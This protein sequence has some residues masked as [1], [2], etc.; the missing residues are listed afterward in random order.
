MSPRTFRIALLQQL[1]ELTSEG[2]CVSVGLLAGRLDAPL[3]RVAEALSELHE[4]TLVDA[5]RLRL[6]LAGLAVAVATRTVYYRL[7]A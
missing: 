2:C 1:Y 5:T 4:A 3:K 7:A 6:T